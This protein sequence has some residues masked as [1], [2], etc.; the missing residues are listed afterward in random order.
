MIFHNHAGG[1][2]DATGG[3]TYERENPSDTRRTVGTFADS[4]PEDVALAARAGAAAQ[5]EWAA[6]SGVDRGRVLARAAALLW[7]RSQSIG[8]ELSA[9]A[10]KPPAEAA[11]EVERAADVLDYFAALGRQRVGSSYESARP[12]V[13][14]RTLRSPRGVVGVITPFNFPAFVSSFKVGAGL[15]AGNAV[16]WKP[17][18][19]T[20]LTG[21][22]IVEAFL[23][24][25]L[26]AGLL[27]YVT[28]TSAALGAAV[29][30]DRTIAAVSFTGSTAVGRA[31]EAAAV[32]RGI[33]AQVEMGG[34]NALV[35]LADADLD[36]A[37]AA[38]VD[39]AFGGAGQKCTATGRV[40]VQAAVAEELTVRVLELT[41]R[42]RVGPADGPDV[43]IGPL[44]S[45][46]ALEA[47]VTAVDTAVGG[48]AEV[49][50]G[51][52]RLTDEPCE[53]GYFVAPTVLVGV[54]P[55]MPIADEEVFGPM[56]TL[57]E[58]ADLDKAVARVNDSEFGL[59]AG[60]F[61]TSLAASETFARL[62]EAG[63]LNVNLPTTGVE[64]HVP[65][66]GIKASGSG[67]KELGQGALDF[68]TNQKTVAVFTR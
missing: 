2:V 11:G 40:F 65:F 63:A 64:P 6:R 12:G 38:V 16:V 57:T 3:G 59:S 8:R 15:M 43:Q 42:L 46:Q 56:V 44:I 7:E 47:V 22:R 39:G 62:A 50:C 45:R 49:L 23:D 28:G 67:P 27:S 30:G 9:E 58:V 24:A 53:H 32:A 37:A 29:V 34:H 13:E 26:P 66:G 41:G 61:T 18:P 36:R 19:A 4:G 20:P 48:G 21:L 14:L 5:P 55:D 54:R 60:I 10:G 51:G 25:G 33:P 52:E 68:Y 35:V 17:S 1:W 31:V